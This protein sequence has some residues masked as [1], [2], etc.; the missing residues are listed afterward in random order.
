[1]ESSES[2]TLNINNIYKGDQPVVDGKYSPAWL[3]MQN[4]HAFIVLVLSLKDFM[5]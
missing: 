4:Y 2:E 1:M 5:G 3:A